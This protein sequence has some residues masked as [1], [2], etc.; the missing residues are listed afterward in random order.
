MNNRQTIKVWDPLVRLF[1]WGA[2][3][4]FAICYFTQEQSYEN[5][6]LSGYILLGITFIRILWGF[7]G[8][9]YARFSDFIYT[10]KKILC[11]LR[12][13]LNCH[14]R[15]YLGHNP[16]GGAMI[17][18]LLFA[19]ITITLS[20]IALDAAEN[21]AGPLGDSSLFQ[22]LST[23]Q[24]IHNISTNITLALIAIHLLGVATTSLLSK[25][26]LTRAMITGNKPRE[27]K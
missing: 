21:R 18:L 11:H 7:V 25:E 26:N 12:S 3:I 23:L 20:G 2:V 9:S 15:R 10:P 22:Y 27:P 4:T 14:P 19:I 6:L 1:H 24:M 8:S 16:A 17:I 13:L 5:H